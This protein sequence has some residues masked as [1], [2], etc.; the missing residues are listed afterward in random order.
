VTPELFQFEFSHFNEK[1]RWAFDWK[2][3][4]HTRRSY[5]PGF[6]MLPIVRLSGQ[7]AV[8]VVRVDG[9]VIAGSG[10]IIDWLERAHPSPALYPEDPGLRREALELQ[11]W[12]D[13]DVGPAVRRAFFFD[14]LPDA[15][16]AARCFT[17]GRSGAVPAIFRTMF[18][19]TRL[20]MQ[21]D[22]QIDADGAARGREVTT[23]ALA[24]AAERGGKTG[25]LVGDRF[26]VADLAAA[27]LLSVTIFPPESPVVLPVPRSE[28][29]RTWL[30]RWA[31]LPGT[32]WVAETYRRHRG[33]SFATA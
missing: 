27:S 16:Y 10:G 32:A 12:F 26:S 5:L 19:V 7:R 11:R 21:R 31:S 8:P 15:A 22:M 29:A 13:A 20:I 3:L 14:L 30:A 2:R 18:P 33:T 1:A 23:Q 24:L 17:G 6:H 4:P 9:R 28:A 25:H